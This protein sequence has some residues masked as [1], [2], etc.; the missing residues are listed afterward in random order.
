[1]K[2][3]QKIN[4]TVKRLSVAI[5]KGKLRRYYLM[6]EQFSLKAFTSINSAGRSC[7]TNRHTGET[8]IRRA[9]TDTELAERLEDV[10]LEEVF[11]DSDGF[12]FCSL[13]HSQFGPFCIA[14]LAVS[15]RKGRAI[16]I[17]CQVNV[18]EAALI[19]PL[20]SKL[21]QL[22]QKLLFI[23][24]DA[25]LVLAMDRWFASKKL[26]DLFTEYKVYFIA[27]T[28]SDKG[29]RLPWDTSW[30]RTPVREISHEEVD[31][32]YCDHEL[33]LIRSTYDEDKRKVEDKEPW[34]LMTNLPE[35]TS[36]GNQD[37][38]TRRQILNRYAERF[39][40]E[41]AFKDIKWVN[42]LEWQQI[43]RP[44]VIYSLLIFVCFGRWLLWW[45]VVPTLNTLSRQQEQARI[46]TK[47]A[48]SWFRMAWEHLE[49]LRNVDILESGLL[50]WGEK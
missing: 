37:G 18:S 20:I 25:K 27:R 1:M 19:T 3:L 23:N 39:E 9:V 47:K 38:F 46:H 7:S 34:F 11:S 30:Q 14:I 40:I 26:F 13:D 29:V 5:E 41:E 50:G 16:P 48:L 36:K 8:R 45:A 43:R 33:R 22:F 32:I 15:F 35:P 2:T 44:E 24:P 31:I 10:L 28:K 49:R 12:V 42:R 21:E 17:W 6:V 4:Q